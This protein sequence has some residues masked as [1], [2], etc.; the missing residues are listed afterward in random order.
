MSEDLE[1]LMAKARRSLE[2]ARILQ[3]H[4]DNDFAVSRAYYAMFY[5]ASALLN[6]KGLSYS[7][8][9]GIL[10]GFSQHFIKAGIMDEYYYD[11]LRFAFEQRN[12]SD[13]RFVPYV[14]DDVATKVISDAEKFIRGTEKILI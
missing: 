14:S 9:S 10:K 4:G 12:I 3:N 1:M 8:H 11:M 7:K 6:W 5:A 13:Y 2:A